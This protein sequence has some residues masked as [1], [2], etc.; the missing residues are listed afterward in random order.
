VLR[1]QSPRPPRKREEPPCQIARRWRLAYR[2]HQYPSF[3]PFFGCSCFSQNPLAANVNLFLL[4]RKFPPSI[5]GRSPFPNSVFSRDLQKDVSE[6][7][8]ENFE[9]SVLAVLAGL[10]NSTFKGRPLFLPGQNAYGW[11]TFLEAD[12]GGAAE[13]DRS[14]AAVYWDQRRTRYEGR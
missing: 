6:F 1:P 13:G 3:P 7:G 9:V 14:S 2:R 8:V 5:Q 4:L 11:G 10:P 12:E